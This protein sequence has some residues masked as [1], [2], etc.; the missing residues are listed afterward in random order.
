MNYSYLNKYF[1]LTSYNCYRTT[2]EINKRNC[3]IHR[4]YGRFP[5]TKK[6]P[7]DNVIKEI[8]EFLNTKYGKDIRNDP[9]ILGY[10]PEDLNYLINYSGFHLIN[11]KRF[12]YGNRI[13]L[14]EEIL[15]NY[16]LEI[17]DNRLIPLEMSD[18]E[19]EKLYI[20]KRQKLR[21]EKKYWSDENRNRYFHN[22]APMGESQGYRNFLKDC[23]KYGV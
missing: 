15:K 20:Y 13:Y 18:N 7:I 14:K 12:Y 6:K 3:F 21:E 4:H 23:K 2:F 1:E 10:Y 22:G 8:I 11:D 16:G 5:I 9:Q 17:M 19:K